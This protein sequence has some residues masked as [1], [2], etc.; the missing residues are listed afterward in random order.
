MK[1]ILSIGLAAIVIISGWLLVASSYRAPAPVAA[2]TFSRAPYDSSF[3]PAR[4]TDQEQAVLRDPGGAIGYSLLATAYLAKA[5]ESD[6][7]D[8]AV[9]AEAAA[10]RS[11]KI[12]TAGN[13]TAWNKVVRAL[14]AQHRFRDSLRETE[15]IQKAKV[16]T[17]ET[18]RLRAEIMIELGRY[19]DAQSIFQKN[20]N[21]FSNT[22][23]SAIQARMLDLEGK[24][25]QALALY[26]KIVRDSEARY[27]IESND[28]AWFH[29]RLGQQQLNMGR[30]ADARKTFLRSIE[31]YPRGYKALFGMARLAAG[32]G[33]WQGALDWA[34][35]ADAIATLPEIVTLMAEAHKRLGEPEKEK[36]LLARVVSLTGSHESAGGMHESAHS[37]GK[38]GAHSHASEE[39]HGHS[40][41]RQYAM[42]CADRN[43]D[44]D[45]AYA[46]A[47][48]DFEERPDIYAYD[49]LAWV[50]FKQKRIKEAIVAIDRALALG[51]QDPKLLYHA[52]EIYAAAGKKPNAADFLR[53]ALRIDDKFDAVHAPRAQGLLARLE[54]GQP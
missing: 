29:T 37:H 33:N 11:I 22:P 51:T 2:K 31:L 52:G 36:Q 50:Y 3:I 35:R 34:A 41:D 8:A 16:S 1:L 15:A 45:G 28:L 5:R 10:R 39:P 44:L 4:I 17:D 25:E 14:L 19:A 18:I 54:V 47:V 46:A 38:D 24:T 53:R 20:P 40:L 23:G 7:N 13:G 6:D 42:F 27:D 9:K 30:R 21:A 26:E 43:Q 48:R 32:D 12:R 49:T